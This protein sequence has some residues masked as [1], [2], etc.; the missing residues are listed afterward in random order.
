MASFEI[1]NLLLIGV[2]FL[3]ALWELA[4]IQR[5]RAK[6]L[7]KNVS[8]LLTHSLILVFSIIALIQIFVWEDTLISVSRGA[9]TVPFSAVTICIMFLSATEAYGSLKA[10]INKLTKNASR[11]ITHALIFCLAIVLFFR[12]I[13]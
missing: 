7:T 4:G 1:I 6:G 8:R 11:I 13:P 12:V 3:L 2:I 9:L 5:A 10:R